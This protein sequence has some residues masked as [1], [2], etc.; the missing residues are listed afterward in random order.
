MGIQSTQHI[1]R[2]NA[3]DRAINIARLIQDKD[4]KKLDEV[5]FEPDYDIKNF[6]DNGLSFNI[7]DIHKWTDKMIEDLLDEPFFRYS[8]FD[9]YLIIEEN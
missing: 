2:N 4:Y 3:V 6:I 7:S 8:M 5:I 1:S 9:N